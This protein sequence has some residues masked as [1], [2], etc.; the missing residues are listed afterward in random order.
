[1]DLPGGSPFVHGMPTKEEL[2]LLALNIESR[3]LGVSL[4]AVIH[5]YADDLATARELDKPLHLFYIE[6]NK[7]LADVARQIGRPF[8][9]RYDGLK[10]RVFTPW[11]PDLHA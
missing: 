4:D 2:L 8:R 9:T 6:K 11:V 5:R 10:S 3:N 1:M 7:I